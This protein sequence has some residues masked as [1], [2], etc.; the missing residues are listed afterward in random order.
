[1]NVC[2]QAENRIFVCAELYSPPPSSPPPAPPVSVSGGYL[3]GGGVL[4]VLGRLVP[5]IGL[6]SAPPPLPFE[7]KC[8]DSRKVNND[9]RR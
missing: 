9:L 2:R 7:L 8:K 6:H 1:M 4:V 5:N 3:S